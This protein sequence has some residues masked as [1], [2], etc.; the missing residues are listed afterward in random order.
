MDTTSNLRQKRSSPEDGDDDRDAPSKRRRTL[1]PESD[2][3]APT[4]A[5]QAE[6]PVYDVVTRP[7]AG[8]LGREGLRRSIGLV[9]K[10]VG[11]DS[12][13]KDALESFTELVDTYVTEFV[14]HL[15]RTANAARRNEPTPADFEQ[16]LHRYDVPLSSLKP[17]LKNPVSKPLLEPSFY[18]PVSEDIQYFHKPRPFLGE[19]LEGREEKEERLWIPKSFPV[20]PSKHTYKFTVVELPPCNPVE[21]RA[22]AE[23][24]AKKGELAL[25]RIDRAAKISKQ[26]E[27][28][29]MA[30]RNP[31]S[32]GRYQAWEQ[33][34]TEFLPRNGSSTVAAEIADHSPLVNFA[35]KFGRREVPRV[36][37]RAPAV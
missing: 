14:D 29:E 21:K 32:Q 33:M 12:C 11:F 23:E 1:S 26:K 18:D 16:I 15:K 37:R 27:L 24:D 28:R 22:Q 20:F 19:E 3:A 34:M 4:L 7:T 31:L 25:R 35:A 2:S 17:H 30:L 9:L 8:D 10:H 5:P 36:S 13:T 6:E